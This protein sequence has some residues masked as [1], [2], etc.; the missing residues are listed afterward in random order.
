MTGFFHRW[1]AHPLTRGKDID[2]PQTTALRLQIIRSKPFLRKLYEEWYRHIATHF[3]SDARVL[4]LGSGAG[5][6]KEFIPQ[7]ITSELF[8]TPGVELVIDAQA[9]AMADASLDGVVMTDVLHHIPDCTS[10][11]HETARVI[12]PGGRVVMIE[13]WNTAWSRWVYQH[14]HHEPFEPDALEWR[15]PISGPLSGAN[16]ALPWIIFQRDRALFE[17]RHPQWALI[18]IVPAMPLAYLL[19][20]GVSLRSFLPGWVY[21]PVR[22]LEQHCNE[23]SWAMFA[24]ITLKRQA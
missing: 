2:D 3:P 15:I 19:S 1:L 5:F 21:R 16:G 22:F 11:F 17:S 10:F 9:I 4:E 8:S 24:M 14:L 23:G 20:G 18:D 12:R 6:L 7:L 13:P